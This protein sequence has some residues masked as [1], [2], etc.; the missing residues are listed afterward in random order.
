MSTTT[1]TIK[2]KTLINLSKPSITE[3]FFNDIH[4]KTRQIPVRGMATLTTTKTTGSG[5]SA[6]TETQTEEKEVQRGMLSFII[7]FRVL[8]ETP[9][10]PPR[11]GSEIIKSAFGGDWSADLTN[12]AEEQLYTLV[13]E[14]LGDDLK[15]SMSAK[16]D[17]H[18]SVP[19]GSGMLREMLASLKLKDQRC[20]KQQARQDYEDHAL[21]T[22]LSEGVTPHELDIW[23]DTA[24]RLN[25]RRGAAKVDNE[26]LIEHTI[27]AFPDSLH[28]KIDE[29]AEKGDRANID[30]MRVAF[31]GVIERH[32]A[33]TKANSQRAMAAR[34]AAA[35]EA[36]QAP[37]EP[38]PSAELL[39]MQQL[40][41]QQQKAMEQQ[42][43]KLER[44]LAALAAAG[45]KPKC[46][47][48]GRAHGGG[49]EACWVMMHPGKVPE[50][51]KTMLRSIH[52]K[53][54]DLKLPDLSAEF[55]A[56]PRT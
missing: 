22:Q 6:R 17:K 28:T 14:H 48:C 11:S 55:P 33:R 54:R 46:K 45:D 4:N 23:I 18:G 26:E 40:M 2:I 44:A 36:E 16:H 42:Q 8:P 56:P 34:A 13:Y 12:S 31:A 29:A 21:R 1:S 10:G 41:E 30:E 24:V 38:S 3:R 19:C 39:R 52:A 51:L 20:H 7:K 15:E 32:R 43:Q 27:A 5:E 47:F 50:S 35:A 25:N 49:E 9:G 53:R 37:P